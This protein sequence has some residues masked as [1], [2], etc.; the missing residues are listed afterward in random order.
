M[1]SKKLTLRLKLSATMPCVNGTMAPPTIE[2]QRS[3]DAFSF[4]Y[5]KLEMLMEKIVGNMIE[6]KSPTPK[7]LH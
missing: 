7:I 4:P 2:V 5:F 1:G 6:L 3:P